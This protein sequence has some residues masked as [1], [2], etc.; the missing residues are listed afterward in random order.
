MR[1]KFACAEG[2]PQI[3]FKFIPPVSKYGIIVYVFFAEV[4]PAGL[5]FLA[6]RRPNPS[7]ALAS[8][9]PNSEIK[10]GINLA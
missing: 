1:P 10:L 2:V 9:R 7:S 3:V 8:L 4:G 5:S 6:T